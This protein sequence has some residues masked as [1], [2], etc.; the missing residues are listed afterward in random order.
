MFSRRG[1]EPCRYFNTPRGCREGQDCRFLH[2][3]AG[4]PTS[5]IDASRSPFRHHHVSIMLSRRGREPC[6]YFNTPGGCRNG[7]DC[8]FLHERAGSPTSSSSSTSFQSPRLSGWPSAPPAGRGNCKFF[9]TSGECRQG[10]N[11]TFR[12]V[13]QSQTQNTAEAAL[14]AT[15]S[16]SDTVTLDFLTTE[17][18]ASINNISLDDLH[19]IGPTEA[20]NILKRF[21]YPTFQF[22]RP[23]QVIQFVQILASVDRRNP[24]WDTIRA[25]SFLETIVDLKHHVLARIREVLQ[26]SPVSCHAG[27]SFT[28]LSFQIGYLPL[29]QFFGSDLILKTNLHHN[30]HALY[31]TLDS[32]LEHMLD[33]ISSCMEEMIQNRSWKDPTPSVLASRQS[34]LSGV[35][36]FGT[37][38]TLLTQYFQ[39][40]KHAINNHPDIFVFA[41]N[42]VRWYD[43]WAGLIM[44]SSFEDTIDPTVQGLTLEQIRESIGRLDAIVKRE[45]A[46]VESKRRPA[47]PQGLREGHQSGALQAHL[48]QTY[49][50][51]GSL[52]PLGPRHDNDHCDIADISILP[53]Q[54]ELTS[55]APPYIPVNLP[56]APHHLDPNS[57]ERHLDIQFRLLREELVAPIRTSISAI[58]SDFDTMQAQASRRGMQPVQLQKLLKAKGGMY[59]N[60][61]TMFHVY[62]NVEYAPLEAERRGFTVGLVVDAPPSERARHPDP[63]ARREFWEHSGSRRLSAG[64]LVVLVIAHFRRLRVYAGSVSSSTDDI[65]ES[66]KVHQSR[67]AI[68]VNFFDPDVELGALRHEKITVD[69]NRFAF[70]MDNNI[71]FESIR[72]FLEK[73]RSVEPTS[74]PF[75]NYICEDN[76]GGVAVAPPRYSRNPRFRYTLDCLSKGSAREYIYQLDATSPL[77][78][79]RARLQLKRSSSLDPS[80]CDAVVDALTQEVALIQGPPGTGKSFTGKELLRVLF[81]SGVRPIVIIAFTNHALDHML[82]S[83]L[84]ENITTSIVRLG[85]RSSDE[86]INEYTLDNLERITD[87]AESPLD[88][89]VRNAYSFMRRLEDEMTEI[90]QHIQTPSYTWRTVWCYLLKFPDHLTSLLDPPT[91]WIEILS[92]PYCEGIE[93]K[94]GWIPAKKR[95]Y[96]DGQNNIYYFWKTGQDILFIQPPQLPQNTAQSAKGKEQMQKQEVLAAELQQL[97]QEY[98]ERMN[99]FFVPLLFPEGEVPSI[100]TTSRP[101]D[102]LLVDDSVW[103]MSI[104]E[105]QTLSAFW[106]DDM[107]SIAYN[108]YS[109]LY[110]QLREEYEAAC[111][112]FNYA[113]DENRRRLLSEVDLI[114][115]TTNGAAKLTSLLTAV[116]PKVL[117]VEEAGQVLEAHILSSLVPSVQHLIC[118]GDPQQLRPTLANFS[119]S[120]DSERGRKLYKFDRSLME[121]L[122]DSGFPMSQ[123]NV[124]R[125][126]RPTISHNI[127]KILYPNLEDHGLVK[128]YPPVQGMENDIF[129]FTHT[130]QEKAADSDGSVS[131]VNIFEV[132]MIVDLVVYL[133]KQEAYSSPGDI[134]VLCAYLGQLR[135]LK[136]ALKSLKVVVSVDER[137]QDQLV[138]EGIDDEGYVEQVTVSQHVRLGTVDNFQGEEAKIVIVSL[139]R[140]SGSFDSENS[141]GFLKSSN[142]I[143]VALSRAQHGLYIL[144]NASNLRQNSTW[145]TIINEMEQRDQ[146]GFGFSV[147]CSRHPDQRNVITEPGQLSVVAPEGGCCFACDYRMDC[148]HI[149]PSVC[150]PDL[151]KHRSMWCDML[152]LRTPCPRMHPCPKRCSDK[153]GPCRFPFDNVEL[154]CGHKASISC[155]QVENLSAVFCHEKVIKQLPLCGHEATVRCS[156]NPRNHRC[157]KAC[158][159]TMSCCGNSCQSSCGDCTELNLPPAGQEF[160]GVLDLKIKRTLH[161]SHR[162]ERLL[163]CQHKCGLDCSQD[164]EC[165]TSCAQACRQRCV[166]HKCSKQ[167]AEDC[168]PCAEPCD[169]ICPHLSC[170]VL[171]GSICARLPCDEPCRTVLPCGHICPSVCGEPCRQQKCIECLSD[172]DK[173]DIVDFVMQRTLAEMPVGSEDISDKL[174]TL[175]C[176]HVFTV[177]TLDGHFQMTD[178]YEVDEMGSYKGMK[179]PPIEFQRP[180]TCPTCQSPI[181]ARRY[182]RISKRANLDILERNVASMM[183]QRL[184][185]VIP[186]IETLS[187]NLEKL[188]AR[189]EKLKV[190]PNFKCHP[191]AGFEDLIKT[192]EG[193]MT[194]KADEVLEH[195]MFTARSMIVHHGLSDSEATSWMGIVVD[196]HRV[197]KKVADIA[198]TRSAHARA[199]ESALST[200]YRLELAHLAAEPPP[201]MLR[202]RPEHIVVRN[203][204]RKIGQPPHK[205]ARRYHLEAF[206]LSVELRLMLG[207]IARSRFEALPVTSNEP[208]VLHH[209][210]VWYSFT[211]FIYQSCV[212]D[213]QKVIAIA[214]ATSSSR[215]AARSASLMF[216]S[217]FEQFRFW[218]LEKRRHAFKSGALAEARDGLVAEVQADK[219]KM[220][221]RLKELEQSYFTSR[222]SSDPSLIN[223]ERQWFHGNCSAKIERCFKEYGKLED[224]IM[225]DAVY[226]PMSLQEKRDI[227]K[228]L[229]FSHRGH[230]YNCINGH[231]FVITECGGAMQASQCPECRAPIGGGNHILDSSNTRAREYEDI[232]RQQ[233]GEASPWTWAAG[234]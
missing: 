85:S 108:R 24:Q 151:D 122:A 14:E 104:E 215:L 11:C 217:D 176:G 13:R 29:L 94:G 192:R 234:A 18:L 170:P 199:Y 146:I 97:Q 225:N 120:V 140:N 84:D 127:R 10:F 43:E 119:L 118:I 174:I 204:D 75:S 21:N 57:M 46:N 184:A 144:G 155:Y 175:D 229:G 100:P 149:C 73:L 2:E 153:C 216:C 167:C 87:R 191:A 121:R 92:G 31:S 37:I 205:A 145:K 45:H 218:V 186:S 16:E 196:L 213:C 107:R 220:E 117:I 61:S 177:E 142:R 206:I 68:R 60:D 30:V 83:L 63:K 35:V 49:D 39:R 76:L 211:L 6:R 182:G 78:I 116:A 88:E 5:P 105:R 38:T 156:D 147:V 136:S 123:I 161:K 56:Y 189:A 59:R 12:H 55:V 232:S 135:E 42:L 209:R 137:D 150:H 4:S 95:R 8:R 15:S 228:A 90:L 109:L 157:L 62:T 52:R 53:T 203:V 106:E 198:M 230:F 169:W 110:E 25:Q 65:I 27:T 133:L 134:A 93:A 164:H 197:Y 162:C 194:E 32:G 112:R 47:Q 233:G 210:H 201:E 166:H 222:P 159:G 207:S 171:C 163:F 160:E 183:S 139:V 1:K 103:N 3:R 48:I 208:E 79:R 101:I 72:P 58:Q 227:V 81:T 181:T 165:N 28:D 17:G 179:A 113:K 26:Y 80:Q 138:M 143:N 231:T 69:E 221:S 50:A 190:A 98:L 188:K 212:V 44:T 36:V 33:V 202:I 168:P 41:G 172:E 67:I 96:T 154:P 102:E 54:D 152:C 131:K 141:I 200:L 114:G 20:H 125:R 130:N 74:I 91:L 111:K 19:K 23:D 185:E 51:P 22:T 89:I 132:K 193:F 82:L 40:F 148:G 128:K 180:P 124:Q 173:M 224:H 70:L 77:S 34:N 129:F 223:E 99:N 7:Q 195:Y 66:S 9:W 219:K 178:Y 126:M 226:Q 214:H 86:R 187:N 64:S 115:C 158:G 71:M